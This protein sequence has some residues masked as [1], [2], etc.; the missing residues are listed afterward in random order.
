[1]TGQISSHGMQCMHRLPVAACTAAALPLQ[2]AASLR[3]ICWHVDRSHNCL[4]RSEAHANQHSTCS[5]H[6]LYMAPG[7]PSGPPRVIAL[8][9]TLVGFNKTSRN[10]LR[11]WKVHQQLV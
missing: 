8:S 2:H 7:P 10:C 6:V 4:L 11:L 5:H 3:K 1:V 9:Q